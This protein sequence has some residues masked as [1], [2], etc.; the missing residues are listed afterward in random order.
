M[1]VPLILPILPS[2]QVVPMEINAVKLGPITAEEK[3]GHK[4]ESLCYY[5]AGKHCAANYPNMSA[6]AKA[7][8][9]AH[10]NAQLSSSSGKA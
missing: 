2:L 4:K 7:D 5:C 3:A 9:E 1:P 6:K 10:R 8:F